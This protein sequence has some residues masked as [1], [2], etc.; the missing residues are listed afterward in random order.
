MPPFLQ[1][2]KGNSISLT[3]EEGARLRRERKAEIEGGLGW[4]EDMRS[5]MRQMRAEGMS[6]R[7]I[8]EA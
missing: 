7:K 5:K 6:R 4:D 3:G 8:G 2:C 1:W